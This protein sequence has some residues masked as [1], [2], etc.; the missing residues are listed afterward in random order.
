M[1][2]VASMSG[3]RE[4]PSKAQTP[5]SPRKQAC[6]NFKELRY[7]PQFLWTAC[8]V[9]EMALLLYAFLEVGLLFAGCDTFW[10]GIAKGSSWEFL[11]IWVSLVIPTALPRHVWASGSGLKCVCVCACV[12]RTSMQKMWLLPCLR[13]ADL[14]SLPL[15]SITSLFLSLP[16]SCYIYIYISLSLSLPLFPSSVPTCLFSKSQV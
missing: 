12:S 16:L 10:L 1:F 11:C 13:P 2:P 3:S 7:Q 4:S 15:V 14:I 9:V 8:P 5:E 6:S